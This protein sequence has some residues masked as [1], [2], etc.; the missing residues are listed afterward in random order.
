MNQSPVTQTTILEGHIRPDQEKTYLH[1]PFNMP[2]NAVRL[3]VEYH[4]SEKIS[5]DPRVMGGNTID[6]GVFDERGIAFLQAGFRGWSGSERPKFWITRDNASPGYLAGTLNPGKWHVLFGLYKIA[7]TGCDY[8]VEISITVQKEPAPVVPP[9][10]PALLVLPSSLPLHFDGSNPSAQWLRGELHCHTW[11]SDGT[12]STSELVSRACSRGM[13]FLAVADHNTIASQRDLESMLEP[14][15]ILIRGVESTTFKGHFNILGIPDWVDFRVHTPDEM[16]SAL[17]F[18]AELGALTSCNHPKPLGP[19][20]DF[21]EVTNFDCVEVW[22]GPWTGLNEISLEYWTGLLAKGRRIPAVG[23][24]DFHRVGERSGAE[25]RDLGIPANW[26]LVS[27]TPTAEKILSAIRLGHA[28]LSASPSGPFLEL[29]SVDGKV[30][31]GDLVNPPPGSLVNLR[32]RCLGGIGCLLRLIDQRGRVYEQAITLA[33]ETVD[34]TVNPSL[35]QF[36]RA[37]L[38]NTDD[39]MRALTNPIYF[40]PC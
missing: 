8:R 32:I 9:S 35:S 12:M 18:A 16:Q 10:Y 3:D 5:A 30:Q 39:Q 6:L 4:Y 14:G 20:W 40:Q 27:G 34:Y 1:L 22:N 21:K 23:G 19:D 17:Q 7:P 36:C 24:S 37:E 11:H 38:R 13:D 31:A 15:L 28:S 33:D 29:S 25:D 26:V 2:E